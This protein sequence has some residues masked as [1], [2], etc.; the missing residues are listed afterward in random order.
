MNSALLI[1][2]MVLSV[3]LMLVVLLQNMGAGLSET[4]GGNSSVQTTRRGP[5][6]FLFTATILIAVAFFGISVAMMF[7]A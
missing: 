4:F 2:Q 1:V 7:L 3:L 5:E 6:K